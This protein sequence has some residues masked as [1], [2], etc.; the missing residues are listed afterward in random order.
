[1]TAAYTGMNSDGTGVLTDADHLWQ[2]VSNI[3]L[4]PL[5]SRVMRR[6]YGSLVPD[7]LDAPQN[8]TTRLQLMSATVIAL[9]QWE[10][11]ISLNHLN[12]QFSAS[13]KTVVEINGTITATMQTTRNTIMLKGAS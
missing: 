11:R 6:T 10:P 3:L 12:V 5:G 13:G 4:T 1:M 7:L 2:S 9:A 8:A